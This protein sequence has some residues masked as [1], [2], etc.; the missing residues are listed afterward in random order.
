VV[1]YRL[2][3][4]IYGAH[5]PVLLEVVERINQFFTGSYISLSATIGARFQLKHSVGV[6]IGPT[7]VIG[8]DVTTMLHGITLGSVEFDFQ[9]NRH[10]T[11]GNNVLL[12]AG[13]IL[14]GNI[15]VGEHAVI[16][17]G[18]VVVDDVPPYSVVIGSKTNIVEKQ[19]Y[20]N[21]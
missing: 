9:G 20:E 8:D 6:V 13:V 16:G 2:G 17:A 5:I 14:L 15:T 11:I 3:H 7:S 1:L 21:R 4:W 19:R 10:P 18:A 12:G